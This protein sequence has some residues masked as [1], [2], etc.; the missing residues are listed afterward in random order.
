MRAEVDE[1]HALVKDGLEAAREKN[2]MTAQGIDLE[3]LSE[4][5]RK[6]WKTAVLKAFTLMIHR[7]YRW[8]S[9]NLRFRGNFVEVTCAYCEKRLLFTQYGYADLSILPE[10]DS[11]LGEDDEKGISPFHKCVAMDAPSRRELFSRFMRWPRAFLCFR[12]QLLQITKAEIHPLAEDLY[13]PD[14][15]IP[16]DMFVRNAYLE[17]EPLDPRANEPLY[18]DESIESPAEGFFVRCGYCRGHHPLHRM[19]IHRCEGPFVD[20][21][22][23]YTPGV[24][25][26]QLCVTRLEK[27][28]LNGDPI[29][30]VE[31]NW[32]AKFRKFVA[33][34]GLEGYQMYD[35][36]TLKG[37]RNRVALEQRQSREYLEENARP[38]V[39][40]LLNASRSRLADDEFVMGFQQDRMGLAVYSRRW[41]STANLNKWRDATIRWIDS[42]PDSEWPM[43]QLSLA[44]YTNTW[45]MLGEVQYQQGFLRGIPS[46]LKY[47]AQNFVLKPNWYWN[48]TWNRIEDGLVAATKDFKE[49]NAKR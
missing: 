8:G 13:V 17:P 2:A 15:M 37:T 3:L 34:D 42:I 7:E 29:G 4:I 24:A 28:I 6:L 39:R 14:V 41:I 44:Q 35:H 19:W 31:C 10:A 48:S 30:C 12:V 26:C 45:Y 18:R 9:T 1:H 49:R 22:D 32:F 21:T 23:G 43:F 40:D 38:V 27:T 36:V 16:R 47:P 25:I 46:V 33:R 11:F 20:V 5:P